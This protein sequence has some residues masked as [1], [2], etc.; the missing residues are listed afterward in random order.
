[1]FEE[2]IFKRFIIEALAPFQLIDTARC[3]QLIIA[4]KGKDIVHVG[5]VR[6]RHR[7]ILNYDSSHLI[8]EEAISFHL[9]R[10]KDA[11]SAV[12]GSSYHNIKQNS[13]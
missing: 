5:F 1:M 10:G 3:I 6:L 4:I 11:N 13:S 12:Q 9:R 7:S 8:K 2:T